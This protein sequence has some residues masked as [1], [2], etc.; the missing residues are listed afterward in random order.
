[1]SI[2]ASVDHY[3][4]YLTESQYH[5]FTG[6]T[7]CR[8]ETWLKGWCLCRRLCTHSGRTSIRCRDGPNVGDW[9][10]V[11]DTS[12][13]EQEK[14][15]FWQKERLFPSNTAG[16]FPWAQFEHTDVDTDEPP[17]WHIW[18]NVGKEEE[19]EKKNHNAKGNVGVF[20]QVTVQLLMEIIL[21]WRMFAKLLFFLN[22]QNKGHF[23]RSASVLVW[24][25][26]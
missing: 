6:T 15:C 5:K 20:L 16:L 21:S 4:G 7:K 2:Q 12:A 24:R 8:T 22:N 10:R 11:C 26:C 13:Q 18:R 19:E 1:M 9:R 23:I 14:Q 25:M 17:T 3:T